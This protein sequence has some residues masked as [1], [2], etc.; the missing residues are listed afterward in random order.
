VLDFGTYLSAF[1]L[2]EPDGRLY[3][4]TY[5]TSDLK[6][7][8][9]LGDTVSGRIALP[10]A[11]WV[12]SDPERNH[13]LVG[14]GEMLCVVDP[15]SGS[16]LSHR[17]AFHYEAGG[18][19][20]FRPVCALPVPGTRYAIL[21]GKSPICE[22]ALAVYDCANDTV[23][24]EGW[25]NPY[26]SVLHNAGE[27]LILLSDE[28][29][30]QSVAL[31]RLQF[32]DVANC[33]LLEPVCVF[34]DAANGI[35]YGHGEWGGSVAVAVSDNLPVGWPDLRAGAR[36]FWSDERTGKLYAARVED[37]D[38]GVVNVLDSNAQVVAR[39]DIGNCPSLLEG[40]GDG[41]LYCSTLDGIVAV[42]CLADTVLAARSLSRRICFLLAAPQVDRLIAV[43]G[44]DST[45][46]LV[47]LDPATLAT[48][49]EADPRGEVVSACYDPAQR[50][51]FVS[52]SNGA[53]SSFAAATLAPV[54]AVDFPTE[55]CEL[56]VSPPSR[57]LYAAVPDD[58]LLV[59]L[60]AADLSTLRVFDIHHYWYGTLAWDPAYDRIY[61]SDGRSTVHVLSC[62]TGDVTAFT[63]DYP[64]DFAFWPDSGRVYV[65]DGSG[66]LV[67]RDTS[68]RIDS[69]WLAPTAA[70]IVTAR[71][72]FSS[73]RTLLFNTSGRLVARFNPGRN[74]LST[75]APGVYFLRPE[76]VRIAPARRVVLV[77]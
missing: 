54:A 17:K 39:L 58:S 66:M 8:D 59:E 44:E 37:G 13:L 26:F 76:D 18:G 61:A 28:W 53:V 38:H 25:S 41:R 2:H 16:V 40:F 60:D 12:A 67:M 33:D 3:A 23:V 35:V 5:E 65:A 69:Q 50:L 57:K 1:V 73:V 47:A 77:R 10:G 27:G 20:Q 6:V 19:S 74:D 55:I 75:L 15:A 51:V 48:V 71:E 14:Y 68:P 29:G 4:T 22:G 21:I 70:T 62:R 32:V 72:W 45:A 34:C 64:C 42:D 56:A 36:D 49:A 30:I 43:L 11:Y 63:T 24:L 7:V 46:V 52:C 31:D 9:P